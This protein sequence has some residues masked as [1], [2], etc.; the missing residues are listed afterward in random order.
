[1]QERHINRKKYFNE[2]IQTTSRFV[3][4]FIQKYKNINSSARVLEI[5]CG[6]GGNLK[7][8]V[9][10]SCECVG[11]DLSSN[12]IELGK[13]FFSEFESAKTPHL[14]VQDIY[15][16]NPDDFG[17]FD[18]IIMRDVI[19]HIHHQEKF[20]AFVKQFLK[21][22]GLFFLGFPPWQNPFGGHQQVCRNKFLSVFPYFHLLPKVMYKSVL[23]LLGET[24]NT[25]EALLEIKQTGISLERF[26]RILK[27]ENY[28]I[29]EKTFF[30]FNPNYEVKFGLKPRKQLAIV[31]AIPFVRNFFTTAAYYLIKK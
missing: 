15:E 1:M 9:D 18:I 11:V 21:D 6:E 30:L 17:K 12:K 25:I 29:V 14:I 2:Q 13:Q 10:L 26:E 23:K 19:E 3:V 28:A 22:D 20:M 16:T 5:G 7:P 27:N 24:D 4:P 8:F 31:S